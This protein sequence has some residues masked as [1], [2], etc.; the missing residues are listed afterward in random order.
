MKNKEWQNTH[1]A[2]H[3]EHTQDR[4]CPPSLAQ[5]FLFSPLGGLR[6]T[7]IKIQFIV[8]KCFIQLIALT[9]HWITEDRGPFLEGPE[10]FRAHFRWHNSLCIS[11]TKAS[12]DTKLC[13]Y[14]NFYSLYNIWK[15]QA[16]L[17]STRVGVLRMAFRT[18]KVLGTLEKRAPVV[19]AF[20]ISGSQTSG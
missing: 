7:A 2:L 4:A 11:K 6:I 3:S 5:R 1:V 16:A 17:Q 12:R 18:R 8:E 10:T 13:S 15:D 19:I 20:P 14:L 9:S